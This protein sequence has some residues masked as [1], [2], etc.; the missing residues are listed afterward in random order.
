FPNERSATS[1]GF[2]LLHHRGPRRYGFARGRL[3]A[4]DSARRE[5]AAEGARREHRLATLQPDAGRL[6]PDRSGCRLAA[7][8]AP[9]GIGLGG[10]Q[11]GGGFLARIAAGNAARRHHPRSRVDRLGP[12]VRSLATSSKKTEVF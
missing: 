12:F 7:A 3:A 10:F 5:P 9:D 6:Y 2:A 11:D 4:S 1:P 8:G